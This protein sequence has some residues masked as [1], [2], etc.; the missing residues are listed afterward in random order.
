[1][2]G[3]SAEIGFLLFGKG[4]GGGMHVVRK[5]SVVFVIGLLAFTTAC[6]SSSSSTSADA[7]GVDL[8]ST[9]LGSPFLLYDKSPF[10]LL[11]VG[12]EPAETGGASITPAR[13]NA[14]IAIFQV[15]FSRF[16]ILNQLP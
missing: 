1:M 13:A 16:S 10:Y 8:P 6:S 5:L 9:T 7:S 14:S 3:Y 12:E 2:E 11:L 15:P 4:L